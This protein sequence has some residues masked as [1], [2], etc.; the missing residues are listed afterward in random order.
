MGPPYHY[1]LDFLL[2]NYIVKEFIIDPE[3]FNMKFVCEL[4]T[5]TCCLSSGHYNK[6]T[7]DWVA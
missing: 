1:I 4:T 3:S 7:I 5:V 6:I 2:F